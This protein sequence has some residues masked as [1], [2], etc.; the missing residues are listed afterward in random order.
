MRS[1]LYLDK[2]KCD[3]MFKELQRDY[4]DVTWRKGS[5]RNQ[6]LH[7]QYVEDYPRVLTQEERG[8]GN[9]LYKT[10]FKVLYEVKS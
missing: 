10:Y 3:A 1:K 2:G 4:P 7:P 5:V 6:L 9:N 8:F